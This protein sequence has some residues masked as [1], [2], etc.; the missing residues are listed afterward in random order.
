MITEEKNN[1]H[2]ELYKSLDEES[3]DENDLCQ[4]TL[5]PLKDKYVTLECNHRFNYEALYN[6]IYKQKYIF[7][8]YNEVFSKDDLKKIGNNKCFIRCPYCRNIQLNL[9][10]YYHNL[11]LKKKYG[12]N[13]LE[14]ENSLNKLI[15]KIGK[16][17]GTNE[18]G[19]NCL[20]L[21]VYNIPNSQL[22]YCKN[23]LKQYKKEKIL[24][25]KIEQ[26]EEEPKFDKIYLPTML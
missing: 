11:G 15:Y 1:F 16:C 4:I 3:D 23:H 6:E 8:R 21:H 12:I 18:L 19:N 22:F 5:L 14:E 9:L 26:K 2:T 7:T 25:E 17:C 10:P 13:S 20:K 24:I